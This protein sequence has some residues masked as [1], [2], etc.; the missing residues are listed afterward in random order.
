MRRTKG[1]T[2]APASVPA[3]RRFASEVLQTAADD[4]REAVVLMISELA[5]NCVRHTDSGFQ[6]TIVQTAGEIRVEATDAGRGAP[7]MRNPGPSDPNGRGLQIVD[8]L[9]SSWGVERLPDGG[10]TVWLALVTRTP[11]PV[12][13]TH[14]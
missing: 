3:A 9:A 6:L 10:K 8:M 1:F 7:T 14:A 2:H 4:A 13:S 5:S 11:A 12:E